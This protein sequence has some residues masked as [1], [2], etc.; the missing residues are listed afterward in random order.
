MVV[1]A[2][3]SSQVLLLVD[4]A[5]MDFTPTETIMAEAA[6]V[7]QL[8]VLRSLTKFYGM[9]A[10]RVG[11]CVSTPEMAEQITAQLPTWPVTALA[12]SAAVEAIS[13]DQYAAETLRTVARDRNTSA[14]SSR[15]LRS[16]ACR[17][18]ATFGCSACRHA[19]LHR[20]AF[21]RISSAAIASSCAIAARSTA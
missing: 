5:F 13:D 16:R 1:R 14:T 2:A 6:H 15:A 12:A 9:P 19:R 7:N 3:A 18:Q 10:L 21:E 8:V 17:P 20:P 4:E 11:Y